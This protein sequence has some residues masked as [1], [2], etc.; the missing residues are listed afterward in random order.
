MQAQPLLFSPREENDSASPAFTVFFYNRTEKK[1]DVI[2]PSE[3]EITLCGDCVPT[4]KRMFDKKVNDV[5]ARLKIDR[6]LSAVVYSHT[7][8]TGRPERKLYEVA[9]SIGLRKVPASEKKPF[10]HITALAENKIKI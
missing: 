6:S 9:P 3:F 4:V 7:D 10:S 5:L 8:L 2:L 1:G